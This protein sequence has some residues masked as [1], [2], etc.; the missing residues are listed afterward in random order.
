L[1]EILNVERKNMVESEKLI[2]KFVA[3]AA[4]DLESHKAALDRLAANQEAQQSQ[5]VE[6][7]DTL[8]AHSKLLEDIQRAWTKNFADQGALLNQQTRVLEAMRALVLPDEPV[9]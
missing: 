4:A 2:G 3:L 5:L 1:S 7:A 8:N 6:F 9:N